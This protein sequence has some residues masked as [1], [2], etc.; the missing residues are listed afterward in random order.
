[1]KADFEIHP[2]QAKVLKTLLF[3]PD[4]RFSELNSDKIST[5]QFNFHLKALVQAGVLGK[6]DG[7]YVLTNKGKE[8]A[9][10]FD[11]EKIAIE[12]QAKITLIVVPI[13]KIGK[14]I[15]RLVHCRL[16][17]PYYGYYGAITGKIRWGEKVL[18]AAARELFEETG[19]KMKKA[20]LLG[21]FHKSDYSVEKHLLEDKYF[22]MVRVDKF[23]GKLIENVPEGKNVWMTEK[24]L[25]ANPMRF[26]DLDDFVGFWQKD[27][28]SF[29]EKDYKVE[30]Y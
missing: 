2:I 20:S 3:K 29:V 26:K 30:G 22:F 17:Q 15:Y 6:R 18:D 28:F 11:T 25:L 13:K 7:K 9:N 21:L 14:K 10:R 8:F 16:K 19:L 27:S 24:E 5:D 1:M 12:K 4:A 23:S